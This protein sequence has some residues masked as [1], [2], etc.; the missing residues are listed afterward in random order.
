MINKIKEKLGEMPKSEKVVL[1]LIL[2][3][4]GIIHLYIRPVFCDDVKFRTQFINA[5]YKIVNLL[6]KRYM[7]WSS[8]VV[9]E[10]VM[11]IM[12]VL[13]VIIWKI[14]D[15]LCIFVLYKI[16]SKYVKNKIL[17]GLCICSYPFMHLGSAGW[18][19]TTT[20]YLWPF[21]AGL[22]AFYMLDKYFFDNKENNKKKL[23]YMLYISLVV[24]TVSNEIF[25]LLYLASIII[26]AVY[27]RER[28]QKHTHTHPYSIYIGGLQ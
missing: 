5:N 7:Q 14:L 24:Y 1:I 2:L 21:T 4:F 15:I 20:N 6:G 23:Y 26:Y 8:R 17:L 18:I 11:Y 13:P 9:I 19:A 28:I 25:A 22:L 16:L 3:F 10:F 12:T 27:N